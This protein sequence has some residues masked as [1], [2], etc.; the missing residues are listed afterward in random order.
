M[1]FKKKSKNN[2][3]LISITRSSHDDR[4]L[5][6]RISGHERFFA[7]KSKIYAFVCGRMAGQGNCATGH[8]TNINFDIAQL[9]SKV[10]KS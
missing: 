2:L 9:L 8:C 4:G 3:S 6:Q 5:K 10:R 7:E 1:K